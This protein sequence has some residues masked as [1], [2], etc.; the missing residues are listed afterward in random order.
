MIVYWSFLALSLVLWYFSAK[1]D[2]HLLKGTSED[3]YK[4]RIKNKHKTM[5]FLFFG[6]LTLFCGLRSGIADTGA[7]INMYNQ[8]PVGVENIVWE[9]VSKDQGFYL[10]SVLF[11]TYISADYHSWLFVICLISC[12][13]TGMAVHRYSSDVGFS[14]FLFIS[15]TMFTYLINGIRQYICVSILFAISYCIEEKRFVKY[16]VFALLLST[17]HFSAILM[18]PTYFLVRIRPWSANTW[19]MIAA[20][21]VLGVGFDSFLPA[22]ESALSESNYSEYAEILANGTGSSVFRLLIAAVPV[23]LSF[24]CRER[25]IETEDRMIY[26]AANMSIINMA[27][28]IVATFSSGMTIG[29]LTIYFDMYN[30]ILIPWLVNNL[31]SRK[32]SKLIKAVAIVAYIVFFYLQMVVTWGWPYMSDV[33][34]IYV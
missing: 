7:Y 11:K 16:L 28:Y 17:V 10:L 13:V 22:F 15:T 21:V 34:N 27:L 2:E 9:D 4:I 23:V 29:R 6:V 8:Y 19:I 26:V 5:L 18:I 31:S 20:A 25:I 24:I 1:Q 14:C 12:I 30:I 3:V 32:E 33:L